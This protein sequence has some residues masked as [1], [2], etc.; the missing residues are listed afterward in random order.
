ALHNSLS[1]CIKK[2]SRLLERAWQMEWSF[3][4]SMAVPEGHTISPDVGAVF[5][6]DGFLD[7]YINNDIRWG[8]EIMREGQKMSD[9]ID[10]F[11]EDGKYRKIPLEN[12]AII[13]FRHHSN[14]PN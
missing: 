11:D 12:W 6:A 8:V 10:R 5:G 13:D 7:F 9:H 14:V 4:A 1:H 3:A 2:N